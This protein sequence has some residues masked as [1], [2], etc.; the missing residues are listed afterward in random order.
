MTCLPQ[1]EKIVLFLVSLTIGLPAYA[2]DAP[3]ELGFEAISPEQIRFEA[4]ASMAP[5][6]GR[7]RGSRA[8]GACSDC[9]T[10]GR[11][12][13]GCRCGL[14]PL[15]HGLPIV[16]RLHLSGEPLQGSSWLNRP[17]SV[18]LHGGTILADSLV[19]GQVEQSGDFFGGFRLGWDLD[20]YWGLELQLG[21][22]EL[23]PIGTHDPPLADV[24]KVFLG[25]IRALYY[26]LGD[27]RFRP[28]LLAGIGT[29]HFDYA[30]DTGG[31]LES[32]LLTTPVGGGVKYQLKPWTVL[33]FDAVNY[34]TQ[35]KNGISSMN[36]VTLSLGIE[37]RLGG[38]RRSYYP[39]HPSR[40]IW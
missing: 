27:S 5:T 12:W 13:Q 24:G 3:D 22:S 37:F 29:G 16:G 31:G 14:L 15:I 10:S 28:F 19:D 40:H 17:Y 20:R 34:I 26:P 30:P 23:T 2:Q 21:W 7:P 33:R 32:S 25:D 18:G 36:N 35:G 8:Q 39:W 4:E 38:R 11:P 1:A 9:S 6:A